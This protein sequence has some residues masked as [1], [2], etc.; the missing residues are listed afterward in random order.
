VQRQWPE[1]CRALRE[2]S[3]AAFRYHVLIAGDEAISFTT[4]GLL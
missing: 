2:R 4:K 1:P 3:R